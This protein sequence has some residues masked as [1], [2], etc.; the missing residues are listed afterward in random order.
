MC[1]IKNDSIICKAV[2]NFG[3]STYTY[4]YCPAAAQ[5]T[6]NSDEEL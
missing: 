2:K 4:C 3:D 6:D 1:G 5:I